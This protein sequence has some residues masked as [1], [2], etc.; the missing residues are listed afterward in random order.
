MHSYDLAIVG[1]G[2]APCLV[3]LAILARR[4]GARLAQVSTDREIGGN[5][6]ELMLPD[7]LSPIM[8]GLLAPA[9][10]LE[11][12]VCLLRAK[13]E[14]SIVEE[15]VWLIDPVQI[16]LELSGRIHGEALHA[17][18]EELDVDDRTV[19]WRGGA[20]EADE[21]IDLHGLGRRERQSEIVQAAVFAELPYPVLADFDGGGERWFYL[22]YAP[23]GSSSA[24]IN[25]VG[26]EEDE[27]RS[28]AVAG[29]MDIGDLPTIAMMAQLGEIC[30]D[31]G[32]A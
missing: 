21:V 6:L 13:E 3:S 2:L 7:R 30:A 19:T 4:P 24:L 22:Q 27:P 10:T 14:T 16:W 26:H 20:I 18:C 17:G 15:R 28:A 9:V 29:P 25:R 12:P 31:H 23:L 32:V 5:R 8:A 11:W 1:D